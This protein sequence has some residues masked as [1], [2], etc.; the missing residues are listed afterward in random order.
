MRVEPE[1]PDEHHLDIFS[2]ELTEISR[3]GC[4]AISAHSDIL[5]REAAAEKH[6]S[7]RVVPA[8]QSLRNHLRNGFA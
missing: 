8:W 1:F 2:E 4:I 5:M 6:P 3:I 7:A